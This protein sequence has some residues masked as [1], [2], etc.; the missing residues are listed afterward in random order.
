VRLDL[1]GSAG[2][3][4]LL[5]AAGLATVLDLPGG[6]GGWRRPGPG[7]RGLLVVTAVVVLIGL[8]ATWFRLD[9]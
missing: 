2:L 6:P 3:V 5:V 1:T 8:V 4:V 9:Q 7:R